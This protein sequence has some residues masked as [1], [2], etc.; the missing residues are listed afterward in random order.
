MQRTAPFARRT[1]MSAPSTR[2]S[3]R[4]RHGCDTRQRVFQLNHTATAAA[5][6]QRTVTWRLVYEEGFIICSRTPRR[7]RKPAQL[8][9][10]ITNTM[11]CL[12]VGSALLRYHGVRK[13][14]HLSGVAKTGRAPDAIALKL[15]TYRPTTF[16]FALSRVRQPYSGE[17]EPLQS[18]VG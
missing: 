9:A 14:T 5:A 15:T 7:V 10:A 6:D 16:R 4:F 17:A 13:S 2:R 8:F 11:S 1:A 3:Q 18:D 12:L